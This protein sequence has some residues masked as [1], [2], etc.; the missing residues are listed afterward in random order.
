MKAEK[1]I[2]LIEEVNVKS[3]LVVWG[4]CVRECVWPPPAYTCKLLVRPS[5]RK[6]TNKAELS[7]RHWTIMSRA[8]PGSLYLTLPCRAVLAAF[9]TLNV[10]YQLV[11]MMV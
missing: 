2:T 10:Q 7:S 3:G 4:V 5:L 1:L 6:L 11:M 8:L 9:S